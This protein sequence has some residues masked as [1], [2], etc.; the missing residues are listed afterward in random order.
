MKNFLVIGSPIG[1]SLSPK[2]HNYW[3]KQNNIKA[4]Y[5]KKLLNKE[6]LAGVVED[7]RNDKISGINITVPYKQEIT[8][9]IDELSPM[10]GKVNSVNTLFKKDG[11]II[12]ENTD[13]YGFEM[14]FKHI[15][16]NVSG[17]KILLLGAGG[18][19]PSL[20]CSLEKLGAGKITISNRTKEKAVKIKETFTNINVITWG[21]T[22][23][24]D[25]IINAT[26]LGLNKDDEIKLNFNKNFKNKLFYDIIYNPKKTN[27]LIFGENQKSRTENGAMMFIYQ[28]QKSFELWHGVK[29]IIDQNTIKLILND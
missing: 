22:V 26:S 20:I 24:F 27:F 10:A 7:I 11:K 13:I 29:P 17:K 23:D 16:Y 4:T 12:G 18:V 21:E 28:A 3:I 19:A 1:H 2:L 5:K 15:K 6:E 8:K 14:A 25:L 9:F